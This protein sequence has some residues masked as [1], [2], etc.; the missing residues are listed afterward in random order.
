VRGGQ[1]GA[2]TRRTV[3]WSDRSSSGFP[4]ETRRQEQIG[5]MDACRLCS[6]TCFGHRSAPA[7]LPHPRRGWSRLFRLRRSAC[8]PTSWNA[9]GNAHEPRSGRCDPHM[10]VQPDVCERLRVVPH[11][12]G[13]PIPIANPMP[14]APTAFR[15]GFH[16]A[17][18]VA[19]LSRAVLGPSPDTQTTLRIVRPRSHLRAGCHEDSP[20]QASL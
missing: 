1:T 6:S 3:L 20:G 18:P 10:P 15:R 11:A 14:I 5:P 9:G 7:A 17:S 13:L 12:F 4:F 2:S 19:G 8:W 16:T